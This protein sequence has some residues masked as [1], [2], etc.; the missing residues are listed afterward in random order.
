MYQTLS[1]VVHNCG[2]NY[3]EDTL[4]IPD[5]NETTFTKTDA[6]ALGSLNKFISHRLF[7]LNLATFYSVNLPNMTYE[8]ISIVVDLPLS[9][10]IDSSALNNSSN[11][12]TTTYSAQNQNPKKRKVSDEN[13]ENQYESTMK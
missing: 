13:E 6:L 3:E 5:I 9:H 10:C 11:T 12:S 2:L 8:I 1:N 7:L 4:P